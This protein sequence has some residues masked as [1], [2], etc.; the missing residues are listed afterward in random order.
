MASNQEE[1]IFVES[2][3]EEPDEQVSFDDSDLF[4]ESHFEEPDEQVSSDDSDWE[5]LESTLGEA[6]EEE[7]DW[8]RVDSDEFI[9]V[10]PPPPPPETLQLPV[11][12]ITQQQVHEGLPCQFCSQAYGIG[13]VW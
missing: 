13:D 12:Q 2:H 4:V 6:A 8:E 9:M 10:A 11:A 3:F 1:L 7:D 5:L